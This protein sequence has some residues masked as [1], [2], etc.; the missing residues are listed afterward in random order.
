MQR[1]HLTVALAGGAL[2]AALLTP[3]LL[4]QGPL[5]DTVDVEPP[6]PVVPLVVAAQ[7]GPLSLSATL[8]QQALLQGMGEDRFW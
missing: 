5:S 8:D 6:V 1:W 7:G 2:V 4:S 3:S